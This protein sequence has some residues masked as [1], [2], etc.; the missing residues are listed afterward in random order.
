MKLP[1]ELLTLNSTY[2]KLGQ[3][4]GMYAIPSSDSKFAPAPIPGSALS[5]AGLSVAAAKTVP[6]QATGGGEHLQSPTTQ[7]LVGTQAETQIENPADMEIDNADLEMEILY[8]SEGGF[9]PITDS[10]VRVTHK[11]TGITVES[12][13]GRSQHRNVY[14]AVVKLKEILSAR[15]RVD[16]QS[17][18]VPAVTWASESDRY[19]H[20]VAVIWSKDPNMAVK[21]E[22]LK[23]YESPF[24][25]KITTIELAAKHMLSCLKTGQPMTGHYPQEPR[26]KGY[27]GNPRYAHH[28]ARR[29]AIEEARKAWKAGVV[30]R[31][32]AVAEWDQYVGKLHA[33]YKR[34]VRT[35]PDDFKTNAS[36]PTVPK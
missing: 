8:R 5:S 18:E 27:Q 29:L 28:H 14:L 26:L 21:Y 3:P 22:Q 10:G 6:G 33:E 19:D 36:I 4:P 12:T 24:V 34:M 23:M 31:R 15:Y 35:S 13:E 7:P 2:G 25:G 11:P 20:D 16:P 1:I 30:R 17:S 9:A 32:Q